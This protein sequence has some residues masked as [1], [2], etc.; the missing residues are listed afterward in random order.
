LNRN[1][2]RT[3]R[4]NR[5]TRDRVVKL[6]NYHMIPVHNSEER[7]QNGWMTLTEAAD[8]LGMRSR[9]L[10]LAA[11]AGEIHGRHPLSDGP[12]L[13]SKNDL[14]TDAARASNAESRTARRPRYQILINQTLIF[15][16]HTI[17]A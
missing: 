12:W 7:V 16:G 14:A 13:F 3:D 11:E 15:S 17:Y 4:G 5:F 6:R 10:R 2:L 1:G 9:T 8:Y